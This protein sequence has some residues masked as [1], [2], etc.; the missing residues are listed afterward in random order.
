MA[1]Y[2]AQYEEQ[3]QD[4]GN[5]WKAYL[6]NKMKSDPLGFAKEMA[7]GRSDMADL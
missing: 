4:N 3:D 6:Y 5:L 2:Y 1:Q 7:E